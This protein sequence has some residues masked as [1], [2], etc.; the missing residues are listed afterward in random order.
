MMHKFEAAGLGKAPF[1]CIEVKRNG[2]AEEP[3]GWCAFCGA[4]IVWEFLIASSDGMAFTVGSHCVKND[5]D[6]KRTMARMQRNYRTI[7]KDAAEAARRAANAA[8]NIAEQAAHIAAK[9][10][11]GRVAQ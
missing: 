3:G 6:L 2:S 5:S 9:E 7:E 11:L 8:Y 10:K 1:E 4:E